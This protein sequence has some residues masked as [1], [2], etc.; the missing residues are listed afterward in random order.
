MKKHAGFLAILAAALIVIIG[1]LG[2]AIIYMFV[3]SATSTINYLQASKAFYIAE[4]GLEKATRY[5]LRPQLTGTTPRIGCS[6]V[7]GYA[8]LTNTS[9]GSGTFSVTGTAA[10]TSA[11]TSL[12]GALSAAST[13]ITVFSTANYASSGRIMIDKEL[14]NYSSVDATTFLGVTRGVDGSIAAS[15]ASGAFV[16]QYQCAL[17]SVGGIPS[18]ATPTNQR[19]VSEAIQLQEAWAVGNSSSSNFRIARWNATTAENAWSDKSLASGSNAN[20]MSVSMS[21]YVDGWAVGASARFLRWNGNTWTLTTV[22]P[23]VTYNGVFCNSSNNCHAVGA[24]NGGSQTILDWNGSSWTRATPGGTTG[25]IDLE[26]V[27]CAASNDCW[28]VGNRAASVKIFYHW[29]GS[30][31]TGTSVASFANTSFPFSGISCGST[32]DCWAVGGDATF[33]HY[34]GGAWVA[35]ATGLP[36]TQY[37]GVFCNNTSDCWAVGNNSSGDLFVH[38]NG[39]SWTRIGPSATVPN[40]NLLSVT[41]AKTPAGGTSNDCWA[42]GATSGGDN[43]AH[44]DGSSWARVGPSASIADVNYNGVTMINPMTQPEAAWQENFS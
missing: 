11:P 9:L 26:S 16:G 32:T 5:L 42:V 23:N 3:G 8:D 43:I 34:T 15:H 6:A 30:S 28:A 41:C 20:L 13:S 27:S 1:F 18:A 25:N 21:S 22:T 24:A 38:W 33:A 7:S 44:W 39:S 2:L 19:T 31:W 36:S 35:V 14:I 12:N 37:N 29:N 4:G 40:A 17:S 10:Y